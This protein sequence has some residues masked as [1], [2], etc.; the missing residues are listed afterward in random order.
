MPTLLT[1]SAETE[2]L[3]HSSFLFGLAPA[4]SKARHNANTGDRPRATMSP[5]CALSWPI[6]LAMITPPLIAAPTEAGSQSPCGP[7]PRQTRATRKARPRRR[8]G[9]AGKSRRRTRRCQAAVGAPVHRIPQWPAPPLYVPTLV[10]G[11][12]ARGDARVDPRV[13]L[14]LN[15]GVTAGADRHA[16][17]KF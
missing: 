14:S 1:V 8:T 10:G 5:A 7:R 11:A 16:L 9:R 3:K 2:P 12:V 4:A 6:S 17:R 13:N 15:V